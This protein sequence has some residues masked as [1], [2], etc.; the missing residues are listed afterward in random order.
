MNYLMIGIGAAALVFGLTIDGIEASEG[1]MLKKQFDEI[2]VSAEG[3]VVHLQEGHLGVFLK[4]A[5]EFIR[6]ANTVL[7]ALPK[8]NERG[9]EVAGHLKMALSEAEEAMEHGESGRVDL[10]VDHALSALSHAEEANS[11]ADRL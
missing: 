11:L 2:M 9:K 7:E 6:R 1:T 8:E 10:A 3:M 5:G 4:H